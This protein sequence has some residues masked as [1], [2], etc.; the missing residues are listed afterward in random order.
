MQHRRQPRHHQL[1]RL[2]GQRRLH[3]DAEAGAGRL[4]E[5]HHRRRHCGG[6]LRPGD[7]PDRLRPGRLHRR[8][9]RGPG[10]LH[11]PTLH[12]HARGGLRHRLHDVQRSERDVHPAGFETAAAQ[13]GY[14]F[15]WFYV[16]DTDTAYFNSGL[17]PVRAPGTDPNLPIWGTRR[18]SGWASTRP[19]TTPRTLR[20]RPTP[21]PPTRTTS[22]AG[23]TSRPR[24]TAPRTATTA[25]ARCS[26][27]TC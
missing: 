26:A 2:P 4:L 22:S 11:R 21:T 15:N 17:N 10:G 18:T 6:L 16:N 3:A 19:P 14:D 9:R 27:S 20:P 24:T 1:H 12:L 25:T 13:V 5:P 8:S 7:V 23:T